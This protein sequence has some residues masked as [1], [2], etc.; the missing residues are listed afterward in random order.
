MKKNLFIILSVISIAL[1]S[2]CGEKGVKY[3][4]KD[5][6][7]S[8]VLP[9]GFKAQNE[10]ADMEKERGGKLFLGGEGF[11][12]DMTA[13]EMNYIGEM[14]P[15]KSIDQSIEMAKVLNDKAEIK[16]IDDI[17][18]VSKTLDEYGHRAHYEIQKNSKKFMIDVT[19]PKDKKE[20]FDKD[21]DAIIKSFKTE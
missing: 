19:Y 14:T 3:E 15:E 17:S 12:I 8:V 13:K 21:V 18:Y 2:S 7:Y 16:K 10:D 9:E 6:G 5:F 4:N 1:L 11:M 20:Q